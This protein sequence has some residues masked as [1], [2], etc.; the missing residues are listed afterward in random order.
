MMVCEIFSCKEAAQQVLMYVCLSMCLWS[1]F[2][3]IRYIP[4]CSR[5]FQNVPEWMQIHELGCSY[6]SLH[7]GPCAYM[8][9]HRLAWSYISLHAVPWAYMQVHELTWSSMVPNCGT[10]WQIFTPL[11]FWFSL[12]SLPIWTFLTIPIQT[13]PAFALQDSVQAAQVLNQ[14]LKKFPQTSFTVNQYMNEVLNSHKR[15]AV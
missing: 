7:A 14:V 10:F 9:F 2:Y 13:P 3:N 8:Q 15:L 11:F 5:M 4:E 6:I 12:F 1:T